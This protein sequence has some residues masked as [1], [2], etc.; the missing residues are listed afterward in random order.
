MPSEDSFIKYATNGILNMP[1][2]HIS[3]YNDKTLEN[4][5]KIFNLEL[6][7]IHHENIQKEHFDFYKAAIWAQIFLKPR[8]ID[9]SIYRKI[10]NRFGIIG[11]KFIK[12]PPNAI[13]HTVSAVYRIKQAL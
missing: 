3:R 6:V 5:T 12:V 7:E 4:I 11:K 10:I 8:L 2:H 1:P 9:E 13:G